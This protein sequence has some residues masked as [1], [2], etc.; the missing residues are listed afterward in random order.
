MGRLIKPGDTFYI[1]PDNTG[2]FHLWI[3]LVVDKDDFD[4]TV[5]VT[6]NVPSCRPS[7]DESCVLLPTVLDRHPFIR[8]KST[9]AYRRMRLAYEEELP[10]YARREAASPALFRRVWLGAT[11]L[12][13]PRPLRHFFRRPLPT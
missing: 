11:T 7:I 13:T 8:C 12:S 2:G 4:R 10:E 6:V 3:V 9:V 5:F 1:D